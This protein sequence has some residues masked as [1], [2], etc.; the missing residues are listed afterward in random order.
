MLEKYT[1]HLQRVVVKLL[2]KYRK[3][4]MDEQVHLKRLAD[5]AIDLF[6]MTAC[7]ARTSRSYSIGLKNADHEVMLTKAFCHEAKER[8]EKNLKDLKLETCD[9]N[10]DTLENIADT[11]FKNHG[12]AAAHPLERNW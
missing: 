9:N 5:I 3:G 8:I 6:G 4:V 1:L 10:D 11:V 7:I 12:Y 2:S